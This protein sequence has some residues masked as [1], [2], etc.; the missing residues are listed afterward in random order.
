[1]G[2]FLLDMACAL[3]IALIDLAFPYVSRMC[4][5]DLIPESKYTAFLQ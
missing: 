1:M 4:M 5:Y 2:L 3:C